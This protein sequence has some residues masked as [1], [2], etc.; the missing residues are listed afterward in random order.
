M[1]RQVFE[2]SSDISLDSQSGGV[3][4]SS[5]STESLGVREWS[6]SL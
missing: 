4:N 5:A 2:A 1:P 3:P 6:M